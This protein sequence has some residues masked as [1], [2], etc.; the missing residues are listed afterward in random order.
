VRL[1]SAEFA[2]VTVRRVA[3]RQQGRIVARAQQVPVP[4]SSQELASSCERHVRI[5]LE[6]GRGHTTDLMAGSAEGS[7][8]VTDDRSRMKIATAA[9]RPELLEEL[10]SADLSSLELAALMID[11]MYFAGHLCVMAHFRAVQPPTVNRSQD[12]GTP[13]SAY[14]RPRPA[15][16]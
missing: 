3:A 15:L 1:P 14:S 10:L 9:E 8:N 7:S 6:A 16:A 4:V 12:T 13:F 2:A 5:A 11:G